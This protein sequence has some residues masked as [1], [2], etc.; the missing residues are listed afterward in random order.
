MSG[1]FLRSHS[2]HQVGARGLLIDHPDDDDGD[3]DNDDAGKRNSRYLKY[4]ALYIRM[5]VLSRWK[6]EIER[7]LGEDRKIE[8]EREFSCRKEIGLNP[9]GGSERVK[10]AK[11]Q[12]L[13]VEKR[14]SLS[15]NN[16]PLFFS[17]LASETAKTLIPEAGLRY[18]S[19]DPPSHQKRLPR[20]PLRFIVTIVFARWKRKQSKIKQGERG[21]F[22]PR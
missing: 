6:R 14:R 19:L 9:F 4:L 16:I 2:G 12:P 22:F 7:E 21:R 11:R 17:D 20:G 5:S 8:R 18:P 15:H 13:L 1:S 10:G 3:D